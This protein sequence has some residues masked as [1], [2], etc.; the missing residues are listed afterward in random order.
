M[1]FDVVHLRMIL[2]RT[3]S[4]FSLWISP[5]GDSSQWSL[6]S[7]LKGSIVLDTMVR[8]RGEALVLFDG[9]LGWIALQ[10]VGATL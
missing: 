7:G 10:H 1:D 8:A 4:K 5:M 3:N 9:H 2:R 6:C